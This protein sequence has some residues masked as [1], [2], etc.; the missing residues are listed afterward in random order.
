MIH[1]LISDPLYFGSEPLAF[2][3]RLRK[4][5]AKYSVDYIALRD[6]TNPKIQKIAKRLKSLN[7][8]INSHYALARR[9]GI[10]RVHLTSSQFHLISRLHRSGFFVVVST[11]S[12]K[13]V[14]LAQKLRAD[15]VTFSPI[16]ATP[17]KP[18]PI[19]VRKLR[20]VVRRTKIGVLA[21]GGIVGAKQLRAIKRTKAAGFASIRYFV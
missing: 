15:M 14:L 2:Q 17:N 5:L 12:Y 8:V 1:Y 4:I 3:K 11:H 18:P 21:L 6:K 10:Q 7:L 13:E 19:G 16:F 20:K 9:L